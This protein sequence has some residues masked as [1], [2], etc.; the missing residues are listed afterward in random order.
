[1]PQRG[2]IHLPVLADH[3]PSGVIRASRNSKRRA[4]VLI[5]V[6][7][8]IILH[9]V[10]WV[11]SAKYGWFGGRTIT[12]IEPSE[13]MEFSKNGV[14]N[15]GLIFFA[16]A[17]LSTLLLGRWFCGWGC[18]VVMLQDFCGWIMKKCGVRPKPF[19][20][21]LL[22]Y[23]PFILGV[24]M[25]ILPAVHRW[26][27]VPLDDG[28]SE[29]WG[30]EHWLVQSVR[31]V[32]TAIG[33]RLPYHTLP[34]WQITSHLTTTDFWRTF[35]GYGV[36]IPFLFVC[37]F[38]VVYFLG[39][40]GFCTYGCPYGGFFAPLDTLSPARIRVTDACEGCGHCTA[41]CTSNVR[42]HEEVRE[43]GMVVDSGCM[44]CLDCVSVCPKDA[45]YFGFAKPA[46]LKGP[47]KN[48][49]PKKIYDLSWLEELVFTGVFIVAF[50]AVRGVYGLVPML[51]AA[52]I[53]G[54]VTF[55]SW[56]LWRLWRDP[57]V[58][59]HR[60]QLKSKQRLRPAGWTFAASVVVVLALTAHSGAVNAILATAR[61]YDDKVSMAVPQAAVFSTIPMR[62]PDEVIE[63]SRT[64][65]KYY[66]LCS[67]L[68]DGGIGLSRNQQLEFDV[69]RAWLH[70]SML[71]Y[72]AAEEILRRALEREGPN[73]NLCTSLMWVLVPQQRAEEALDFAE[74]YLLKI[75][76]M[77]QTLE[78]FRRMG[79]EFG[80]ADRVLSV[81][82]QRLAKFPNHL[83]TMRAI[84]I[85]QFEMGQFAD[86][87]EMIR[88]TLQI[89][90]HS[91]GGYYFLAMGLRQLEKI[92]E[93]LDAMR[94][95]HRLDPKSIPIA[96]AATELLMENGRYDEAQQF[97]TKVETL[98]AEHMQRNQRR[99]PQ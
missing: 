55:L 73:D 3:Q 74:P 76:D 12:P 42:V 54:I 22:I 94:E 72:K 95:A 83:N 84:S 69:R 91:A 11:M 27:L 65:L 21:R 90:P 86:A 24:Y 41:V 16:A 92:D 77:S 75:E 89:D 50:I 10:L 28:M 98:Q 80:Q 43:Y 29:A 99:R 26:G 13:A 14:I 60:W 68:R 35:A 32:S 38:A 25:F 36:A 47:A 56:K 44:K 46:L 53:A 30:E 2:A 71:E 17:L 8:L 7:V 66:T 82:W 6:Q 15:A 52:G 97:R 34:E 9:I 64:G 67:S 51:M 57:N 87:N 61:K 33:F 62:P 79:I 93:A 18:H 88:K 45:L 58:T 37:G 96:A 40:K 48:A 81:C 20:S 63:W 70:A 23:V 39:A 59:M 19:R 85:M 49:K 78:V 1:M 5:A 31:W 4:I